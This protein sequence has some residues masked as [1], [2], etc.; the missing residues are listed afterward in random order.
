MVECTVQESTNADLLA[1]LQRKEGKRRRRK[2]NCGLAQV[3]NQEVLDERQEADDWDD[4]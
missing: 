2:G 3:V 4:E 1:H